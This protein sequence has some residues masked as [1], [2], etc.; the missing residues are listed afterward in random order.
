MMKLLAL[1][2]LML[3]LPSWALLCWRDTAPSTHPLTLWSLLLSFTE[4]TFSLQFFLSDSEEAIPP[5]ANTS[6]TSLF[7]SS[8]QAAMLRAQN[9][10]F[11][12][13][14]TFHSLVLLLWFSCKLFTPSMSWPLLSDLLWCQS[15][16]RAW[17]FKKCQSLKR[18]APAGRQ[19]LDPVCR[20]T[21]VSV[22]LP[23]MTPPS[24]SSYYISWYASQCWAFTC[25]AWN[26]WVSL[27]MGWIC[28][29]SLTL[30]DG[31]HS[32]NFCL[33]LAANT[34]WWL[35]PQIT[36]ADSIW[37]KRPPKIEIPKHTNTS[38]F[39]VKSIK[40]VIYFETHYLF[41]NFI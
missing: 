27:L 9:L 32:P 36:L 38:A 17:L 29:R 21:G 20:P 31:D 5:T 22:A 14:R 7:A 34:V 2:T 28:V 6:N 11:L 3:V 25:M 23:R 40:S 8:N 15:R 13:V 26:F 37:P 33:S 30:Y 18:E 19:C 39:Q 12:P 35:Y 10:F 4:N 16:S 1:E 41:L 24:F